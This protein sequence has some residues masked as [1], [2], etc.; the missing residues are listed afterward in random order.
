MNFRVLRFQFRQ[1]LWPALLM[2]VLFAALSVGAAYLFEEDIIAALSEARAQAPVL[3]S[4]LGVG[5]SAAIGSHLVSLLYGLL[6]PLL[7]GLYAVGLSSALVADKVETGEISYWL[8]LPQSRVAF[9]AGQ[10]LLMAVL[11]ALPPAGAYLASAVSA[12]LVKPEASLHLGWHALVNGGLYAWMLLAGA[13]G[14]W[15]SCASFARARAYRLGTLLFLLFF[16][17]GVAG[18]TQGAPDWLKWLS[19]WWLYMPQDLALGRVSAPM[20]GLPGLTVLLLLLAA[21]RFTV[22]DLE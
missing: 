17:L 6:L 14:L 15:V 12:P 19:P 16:A 2:A 20:L 22:R 21:G 18:M 3:F 4:A 11:L 13:L 10:A 1:R 8:S 5:G 9:V 7:G